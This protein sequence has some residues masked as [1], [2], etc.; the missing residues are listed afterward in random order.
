MSLSFGN[1]NA[2]GEDAT[3]VPG[4]LVPEWRMSSAARKRRAIYALTPDAPILHGEFGFMEGALDAWRVQG[5]PVAPLDE[6]FGYEPSGCFHLEQLGWTEAALFPQFETEVLED[7]GDSE[8]VRDSAGRTVLYFKGRRQGFMPEYVEHPVKDL[9]TWRDRVAWRLAPDTPQRL[10]D[11]PAEMCDARAAQAQGEMIVQDLIG[12]YMFL[13]SLIGP[14]DLLYAFVDQPELIHACM[15]AWFELAD[16][17]IARHQEHVTLDELFLAEDICYNSGLLISP[18]MV[19]EFLFPYYKRLI[20][21]IRA[22]QLDSARHLYIQIDTDGNVT[23][24]AIAMYQELGMDVMSPFEVAS[25][26]DVVELGRR[27]P[28]LVMR[29]GID[30]RVLAQGPAAIDA[31]VERIIPVMRRRGGYIPCCDHCVPCEVKYA[32]YLHYRRRCRELGG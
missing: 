32:D 2:V 25:G 26:C 17:V 23:N 1:M 11:L 16:A 3:G 7:R 12:G 5:M 10:A 15:T 20:A 13:R 14:Q 4:A 30:K 8:L 22:R 31:M 29:G 19:R 28:T 21:N 27:Y 6:I 24:G 9:A 18:E